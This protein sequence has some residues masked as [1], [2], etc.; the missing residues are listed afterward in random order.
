MATDK[1]PYP[2]ARRLPLVETLH[3][4]MVADP[5]RW[6]EED[7]SAETQAWV[8][9]ENA[10]TRSRLDG[11]RRDAL[12]SR[13]RERYDYPR[14]LSLVSRGGHYFFTHNPGLLDQP[15]LYV[16][17]GANGEPRALIDPN[18]ISAD[19]TTA[20]TAHA[21]SP[22]GSRVAYALSL[23]GSDRQVL[24]VLGV[25]ASAAKP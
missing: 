24:R 18:T 17:D 23:H 4:V 14:T 15:V 11:P 8:A 22:D 2:A 19:G 25:S 3:G 6:L 20:L 21:V 10:L 12:V 16:Q 1:I 7:G 13:L 9:A 5:Y